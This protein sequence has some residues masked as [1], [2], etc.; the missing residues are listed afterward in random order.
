MRQ[1]SPRN[2][3]RNGR[4][5]GTVS[6]GVRLSE[7]QLSGQRLALVLQFAMHTKSYHNSC[8]SCL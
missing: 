1:G 2:T 8:G 3:Y 7:L 4:S 5:P 6:S